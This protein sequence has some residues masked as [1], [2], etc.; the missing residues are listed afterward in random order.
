M[1]N[2]AVEW[3]FLENANVI[4]CTLFLWEVA[5]NFLKLRENPSLVSQYQLPDLYLF[6]RE[7]IS[8]LNS[9]IPSLVLL[10]PPKAP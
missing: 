9:Q 10:Y 3:R 7:Y 5:F 4:F 6:G 1:S 8:P 2:I